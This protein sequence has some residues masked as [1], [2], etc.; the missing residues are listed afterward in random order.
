[1]KVLFLKSIIQTPMKK[2]LGLLFSFCLIGSAV[3]QKPIQGQRTAE[4]NLNF[5]TGVAAISYNLPAEL[6]FRYFLKDNVALRLRLGMRSNSS[7]YSVSNSQGTVISEV[8]NH[9]GFGLSIFPGYE[10]HFAGTAKLSPFVGAQLGISLNGGNS[11]EVSNSGYSNPS[12]NLVINGDSYKSKSGS[13][14][15]LSLG[16]YMGADYYFAEHL[17]IGGEF[18][19]GLFSMSSTGE[20]S[21]KYVRLGAPE[22]NNKTTKTSSSSL[23]GVYTG[24]VRLG[25]V[26]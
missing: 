25:F 5:Q 18:G 26:F 17:Y 20:G 22:V 4:V 3:A 12:T 24:G 15:G 10:K 9:S 21:E 14:L 1:M 23:F 7:K 2:T 16:C 19:L 8:V 13:T 11:R 6:R